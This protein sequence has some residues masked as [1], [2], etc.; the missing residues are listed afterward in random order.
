MRLSVVIPAFNEEGNIGRLIEETFAAVPGTVLGEVIVVDDASEDRT[1]AEIKALIPKFGALHYVR[2]G[3]RAGQS[4][5][6]RTGVL[7]ARFP[8]V[9][10]MDG[11]GQNDPSDIA[12]LHARL[13]SPGREPTLVGGIRASRKDSGSKR[14][15][16]R[17]ANWLRDKVLA[18]GCP[19]TGCGLKVYQ[20]DAYLALPFFTSMHRYLPAFFL[21]YGH[22]VVYEPVNDRPR[23]AGKSKY[24]NFGRALIGIYDLVGVTWLRKRT[25]LVP[26]AEHVPGTGNVASA[27]G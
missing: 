3:R 9:A 19:D 24:T 27:G 12:R 18:D 8:A 26:L 25:A 17:F 20:R 11:D 2:H 23:L 5:A 6:L 15:A 10:A 4:A 16:S 1:G 22:Q 13:A 14:L 7:A 21:T